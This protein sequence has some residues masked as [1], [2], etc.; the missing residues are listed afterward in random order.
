M[1]RY[2]LACAYFHENAKLHEGRDAKLMTYAAG[3][4]QS[5]AAA[6]L[7]LGPKNLAAGLYTLNS[8]E[9]HILKVPGFNPRAYEVKN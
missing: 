2:C 4:F 1:R 6:R 5:A 7:S 8:V 9:T 3:A